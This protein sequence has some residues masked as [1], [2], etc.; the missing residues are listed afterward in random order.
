MVASQEISIY[1][2][3][4]GASRGREFNAIVRESGVEK[5][6]LTQETYEKINEIKNVI[7]GIPNRLK[8]E[9]EENVRAYFAQSHIKLMTTQDNNYKMYVDSN[10]IRE[11][12][13]EK[14]EWRC[15][16]S[17]IDII[18]DR[19]VRCT[20]QQADRYTIQEADQ[21]KIGRFIL[22][23]LFTG[24]RAPALRCS[25]NSLNVDVRAFKKDDEKYFEITINQKWEW[26]PEVRGYIGRQISNGVFVANAVCPVIDA[27]RITKIKQL[28]DRVF[29][30]G[31]QH[32]SINQG[33]IMIELSQLGKPIACDLIPPSILIRTT[34][35][36]L[37]LS[38]QIKTIWQGQHPLQIL[39]T[40][41]C[42]WFP[43]LT[44]PALLPSVAPDNPGLLELP[45]Q[46]EVRL[47]TR[48]GLFPGAQGVNFEPMTVANLSP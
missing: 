27:E 29:E 40:K 12:K 26:M 2:H 44:T 36:L 20:I 25:I 5:A 11:G 33:S 14:L 42:S 16:F 10:P 30:N 22:R 34:I 35:N 19:T 8:K 41:A 3:S 1:S 47:L 46:N 24:R 28:Q 37:M 17:S 45:P 15:L 21:S 43:S 18:E 31:R 48:A 9:S 7:I 39:W 13:E 4:A 23:K 38:A 32:I 6:H